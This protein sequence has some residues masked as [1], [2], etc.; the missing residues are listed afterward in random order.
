[1][2][3]STN[4]YQQDSY[5]LK[6]DIKAYFMNMQH[7]IIYD[8]MMSFVEKEKTYL[9]IDYATIEF[10]LRKTIFN[11]ASN[12]SR[13]IRRFQTIINWENRAKINRR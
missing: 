7:H 3:S 8:K 1:M 6:L 13:I 5:V 4:N 11:N 12:N 10:L 2:R 9:G